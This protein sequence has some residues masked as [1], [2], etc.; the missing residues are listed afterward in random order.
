MKIASTL[1]E[2]CLD[3]KDD[4]HGNPSQ[5]GDPVQMFACLQRS[6]QEEQNP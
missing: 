5:N 3:A 6:N 4:S 2:N 1:N